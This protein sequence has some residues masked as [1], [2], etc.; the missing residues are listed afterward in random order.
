M[1]NQPA[2]P[3]LRRRRLGGLLREKREQAHLTLDEVEKRMGWVKTRLSKIEN[4]RA[5]ISAPEVVRLL[6]L[7]GVDDPKLSEALQVLAKS[8]GKQGWWSV[9][10]DVAQEGYRD[11]ISLDGDADEMQFY[12][13]T[14]VPG[15]LQTPRYARQIITGIGVRRSPEQI[16]RLVELRMA[17]QSVLTRPGNPLKLH[18]VMEETALRYAVS[19]SSSAMPEQMAR[20]IEMSE[21]PSITIQVFP[22]GAAPHPGMSGM[23][24]VISFPDPWPPLVNA[25]NVSGNIFIEDPGKVEVFK[26][27]FARMAERALSP[28]QTRELMTHIVKGAR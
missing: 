27:A 11:L 15:L 6:E 13:P 18:A 12:S 1:P 26:T 5:H 22:L 20:L 3:T 7:Y 21:W 17:R 23:F 28:E 8:A 25:E 16:Q 9:Y 19:D 2:R 4:A 24:S 14:L 10:G